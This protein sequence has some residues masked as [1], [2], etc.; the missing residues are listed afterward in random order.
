MREKLEALPLT[1]LRE[2][3]KSR[4]LK[5]ISTAKKADLIESLLALAEE[6][7]KQIQTEH[8]DMVKENGGLQTETGTDSAPQERQESRPRN[9][10]QG[11]GENRQ[12]TRSQNTA[13]SRSILH[14]RPQDGGRMPPEQRIRTPG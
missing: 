14:F 5:R 11:Q 3:A 8:T 1:E 12:N 10:R 9:N 6:E 4:G 7:K 2:I 13:G